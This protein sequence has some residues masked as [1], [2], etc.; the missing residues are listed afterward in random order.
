MYFELRTKNYLSF[1]VNRWRRT[2]NPE[3]KT[4]NY[5]LNSSPVNL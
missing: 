2:Q 5:K 4:R 1:V 3:L